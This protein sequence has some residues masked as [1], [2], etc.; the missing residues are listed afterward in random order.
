MRKIFNHLFTDTIWSL[1]YWGT[2]TEPKV[3]IESRNQ[4]QI[5]AFTL[6]LHALDLVKIPQ[7]NEQ[8]KPLQWLAGLTDG[9]VFLKLRQGKNPGIEGL[10]AYDFPSGELRYSIPLKQWTSLEHQHLL[11]NQGIID[12]VTGKIVD[13]VTKEQDNSNLKIQSPMHFEESQAEFQSKI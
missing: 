10:E 8:N 6:D 11:T 3:W 7:V 12:L 4:E 2:A 1:G 13:R 9:G 5:Q